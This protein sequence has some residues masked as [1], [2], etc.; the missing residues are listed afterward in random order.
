MIVKKEY[1][2]HQETPM[3]HFQSNE[4]GACLRGTEVKPK[5]DKFILKKK[6][7]I[8]S[9][10]YVDREQSNALN[11]KIRIAAKEEAKIIDFPNPTNFV[12]LIV[13]TYLN[14]SPLI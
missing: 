8:P 13:L 10:W 1:F 9:E 12:A 5:L 2:L 4:E 6:G 3:I 14:S 7:S 11:Y